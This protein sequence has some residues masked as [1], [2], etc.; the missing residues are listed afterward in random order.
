MKYTNETGNEES[1]KLGNIDVANSILL[2]VH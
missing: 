2:H 1:N